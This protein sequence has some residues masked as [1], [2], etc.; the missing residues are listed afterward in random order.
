MAA[1]RL[2]L[3]LP[4]VPVPADAGAKLRN[5][6]LTRALQ[7][8]G[9][10]HVD[11]IA[12]GTAHEQAALAACTGS[13]ACVVAPPRRAARQRVWDL[14]AGRPDVAV[15]G[16]SAGFAAALDG[17]LRGQ[18]YDLVQAEGIEMAPY[19]R[20]V[21]AGQRVYDAHNAEFLLQR[22]A[23]ALGGSLAGRLY[24]RLQ[25]RRLERFERALVQ[26]SRLVLAVSEHDANQLL[27]LAG[28]QGR[29]RV[30]P[31]GIDVADYPFLAP[32]AER[33]PN[34]LLLGKLDFR[35]NGEAARWLIQ[36]VL[37]GVFEQVPRARLLCVGA[38]PPAWLV[39]AGQ[40]EPRLAVTGYVA[41]ERPYLGRAMAMLLPLRLGGG[42]RLKA[43]VAMAS[44][45]PIVS[46]RLGMEGLEAVVGEHYLA[47]ETPAEWVS[48]VR[49][50]A[51]DA[52]LRQRLAVAARRLVEERYDWRTIGPRLLAAYEE[53]LG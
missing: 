14:L 4:S 5:L 26:H 37:P 32:A 42:T 3:L 13:A 35:P 24:S 22:R 47:A 51:D 8:A 10:W 40:H 1:R 6:G 38:A 19:L 16:W 34:L 9:A 44:G 20:R 43:L 15:R 23:S 49:C 36:T 11:A 17:A 52:G 33:D 39:R 2:L 50:L 7:R 46:T 48:A 31:N 18:Q 12:F 21:P 41:D 25:W 29:V 30:V 53:V 28:G 45:V 27:A